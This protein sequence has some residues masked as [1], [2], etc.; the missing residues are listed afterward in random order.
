M[1]APQ[2]LLCPLRMQARINMLNLLMWKQVIDDLNDKKWAHV[3]L[4]ELAIM[5][6][7]ATQRHICT[8]TRLIPATSAS[9]LGATRQRRA[10]R[11]RLGY[12]VSRCAHERPSVQASDRSSS[13]S[14]AGPPPSCA[15]CRRQANA[16]P[17][18]DPLTPLAAKSASQRLIGAAPSRPLCV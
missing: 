18:Q 3:R 17:S 16:D 2:F 13:F 5:L 14:H 7:C 8:W 15:C 9:G 6:V 10:D 4:E 11:A 12:L 1:A